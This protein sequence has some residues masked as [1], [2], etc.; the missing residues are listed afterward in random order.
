LTRRVLL[1]LFVAG[2]AA[3]LLDAVWA[4]RGFFHDDAYIALRYARNL[5][6]GHG[7]LWNP[8]QAPVEGYT[9]LVAVLLV[10]LPA[11]LGADPVAAVRAVNFLAMA[12]MVAY[13]VAH[14]LRRRGAGEDALGPVLP[15][16][17]VACS[18]PLWIW[19]WGG[20]EGP[21]FAAAVAL[22]AG[23]TVRLLAE[24]SRPGAAWTA[25]LAAGL[26]P[27]VRPDGAAFTALAA[28]FAVIPLARLERPER[29][30]Q[31]LRFA[32]ALAP[33]PTAVL[34]F[35]LLYYGAWV[36]NTVTAK[37][38]G[39]PWSPWGDGL[40]YVGRFA[41]TPPY[42]PVLAVL[43]F[44]LALRQPRRRLPACY[45]FA[46]VLVYAALVARAGGDHMLA[47]RLFLPL[48]P[49]VALLLLLGVSP[50]LAG[51]RSLP[52]AAALLALG[53][54]LVAQRA[55]YPALP[56]DPA[57]FV[58]TVVGRHIETKWP[59]GTRVALNTA[60]STPYHA[61]G[62]TYIDMLGLNDR[63][64]AARSLKRLRVPWQRIPG[65]AKGDGRYVLDLKPDVIILGPA[66]GV[67]ADAP[68]FLGDHEIRDLP[69]FRREY[70]VQREVID[71]RD[72]PG[73]EAYPATR[74][75]RLVFTY[76]VR[77]DTPLPLNRSSSSA[78]ST[79][80]LVSDP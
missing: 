10:A 49:L 20:L 45:V 13:L 43:G 76:Y 8:G 27:A 16:A 44:A 17:L 41:L 53:G 60:G 78:N 38:S 70:R 66:E 12:G 73:Y 68:W 50:L 29:R 15:V 52:A 36:P 64:I 33:I 21:L 69:R 7:L 80:K 9:S 74:T 2:A 24:P 25:G 4:H 54:L 34:G 71:V 65:H 59:P 77:Q 58:G 47:W 31:L 14:G 3:L 18:T 56:E 46:S 42:L 55:Q 62:Y 39:I 23:S 40:R 79:L 67:T 61:A 1:G 35:R 63:H 57:A 30:P 37:L 28:A 48:V 19:A 22:A 11:A 5:A 51:G 6:D 26:L 72:R 75:G 32:A